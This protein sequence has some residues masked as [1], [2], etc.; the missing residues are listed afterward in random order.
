MDW[1]AGCVVMVIG[2]VAVVTVSVAMLLV[3]MFPLPSEM[4]TAKALL[5]SPRTATGVV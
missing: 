3:R 5:L 2:G 4:S 1:L